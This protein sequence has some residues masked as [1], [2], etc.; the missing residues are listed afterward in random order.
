MT[1]TLRHVDWDGWNHMDGWGWAWGWMWLLPTLLVVGVVA[2]L[3]VLV[4]AVTRGV[5]GRGSPAP[6]AHRSAARD[7]LDQR[8]ARGELTTEEY[9]ERLHEL[10]ELGSDKG[11]P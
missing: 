7:I 4:V 9:R 5:A 1:P 3:V 2:A 6:P 10:G 8:Y 11:H